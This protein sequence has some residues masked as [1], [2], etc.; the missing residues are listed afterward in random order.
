MNLTGTKSLSDLIDVLKRL[1]GVG[2]KM[3]ERLALHLI[4]TQD[5][6][7]LKDAIVT[8]KSKLRYCRLCGFIA[9]QELCHMCSDSSRRNKKSVC[10]VEQIADVD[11]IERCGVH[12]GVYHVLGGALS[13]LDGIGPEHLRI[14]PLME[15]LRSQEVEEV[16]IAANTTLEGETTTTYLTSLI[17]P[18]HIRVTRLGYGL[19]SGSSLEYSDELTITRAFD[20]RKELL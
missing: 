10:I 16:I 1:P 20:S 7:L 2:P 4:R 11:A 5:G 6:E 15:R 9:E 17:K 3:A 14:S 19:P 8:A 12:K 18:L 13:P